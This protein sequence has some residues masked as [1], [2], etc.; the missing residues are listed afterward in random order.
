MLTKK[1]IKE[2]KEHLDKAQ[3]PIFFFD[4]DPDGL[5]SF[6]LLQRY[7]E[8]GKGAYL[9]G[10]RIHVSKRGLEDA[11]LTHNSNFHAD[12]EKM[13]KGFKK[14]VNSVFKVRMLGSCIAHLAQLADGRTDV[15]VEYGLHPWDIF[16]GA[17]I[18]EEAGGKVTD[19]AGK[20]WHSFNGTLIA[21]NGLIHN[22]IQ[23]LLSN[24]E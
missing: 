24:L 8:K 5:C 15:D 12:G 7:C 17:L 13:F 9:N 11:F 18:V 20:P 23:E 1:Q 22:E 19:F 10:E 6:L 16:A 14:L 21:S 3:N 2:I 4:N